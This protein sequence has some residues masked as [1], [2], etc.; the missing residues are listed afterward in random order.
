MGGF[1]R[2]L[3]TRAGCLQVVITCIQRFLGGV[4][5]GIHGVLR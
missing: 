4:F 3:K 2:A 5:G 1:R